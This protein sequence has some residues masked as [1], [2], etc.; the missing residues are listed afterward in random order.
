LP[1]F[2]PHQ[3]PKA[4]ELKSEMSET[5]G[6]GASQTRDIAL[7]VP[8]DEVK[9]LWPNDDFQALGL[10]GWPVG[11]CFVLAGTIPGSA[12]IMANIPCSTFD[13]YR[14]GGTIA[15]ERTLY[16]ELHLMT[17]VR[18]AIGIFIRHQGQFQH[19]RAWLMINRHN[20]QGWADLVQYRT[21]HTLQH[22][23]LETEILDCGTQSRESLMLAPSRC[24][25]VVFKNDVGPPKVY[26]GDNLVYPRHLS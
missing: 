26:V 4:L 18:R 21:Q 13:K 22:L 5:F 7:T 6:S 11:C 25:V 8:E 10:P 2:L 14:T 1:T 19:P 23:H 24:A 20:C 15:T 3:I 16:I 12:V 9:V 17:M